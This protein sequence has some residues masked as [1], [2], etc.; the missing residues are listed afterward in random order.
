MTLDNNL[1]QRI[2][3]LISEVANIHDLVQKV[4]ILEYMEQEA[5]YLLWQLSD[6]IHIDN[7][8]QNV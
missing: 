7:D 3:A 6:E 5:G 2:D 8:S 4:A 1:K